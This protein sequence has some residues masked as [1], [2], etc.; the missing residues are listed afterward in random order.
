[1][2]VL[3]NTYIGVVNLSALLGRVECPETVA[4]TREV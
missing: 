2:M 3:L 4:E 1:M